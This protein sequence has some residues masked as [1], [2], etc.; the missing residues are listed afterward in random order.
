MTAGNLSLD[1]LWDR[2][3]SARQAFDSHLAI[4]ALPDEVRNLVLRGFDETSGP[5]NQNYRAPDPAVW[6]GVRV[7]SP[8]DEAHRNLQRRAASLERLSGLHTSLSADALAARAKLSADTAMQKRTLVEKLAMAERQGLVI[9]KGKNVIKRGLLARLHSEDWWHAQRRRKLARDREDA[10]RALGM[11]SSHGGLYVSDCAMEGYRLHQAR[12]LMACAQMDLLDER[13]GEVVPL[14]EIR[15]GSMANPKN[16]NTKMM[17]T[18]RGLEEYA[19]EVGHTCVMVTATCPSRFHAIHS[20]SGEPNEKFDGSTPRQGQQWLGKSWAKARSSLARRGIRIYGWRVA[21]PHHDG[22]PHWHLIIYAAV[23]D[24]PTV[25]RVLRKVWLSDCGHE[26]GALLRRIQFE[27]CDPGKSGGVGYLG[28]YLAKN[29]DG[30]LPTLFDGEEI[31]EARGQGITVATARE[32]AV[33]W[34]RVHGIRQFQGFGLPLASLWDECRRHRGRLDPHH[35]LLDMVNAAT[36][37]D[38]AKLSPLTYLKTLGGHEHWRR[39]SK[40]RMEYDAPRRRDPYFGNILRVT[41]WGELPAD[42]PVGLKCIR[43]HR[44]MHKGQAIDIPRI[45]RNRIRGDFFRLLFRASSE[46]GPV[47]L[48]VRAAINESAAAGLPKN[49]SAT[50]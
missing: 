14:S 48:T 26:P 11:V 4:E 47:A 10:M 31:D 17:V 24:M 18:A 50:P 41:R 6:E 12:M 30:A 5:A 40:C 39:E 35:P 25:R 7:K 28:K 32:R 20:D 37:T 19:A 13:T 49:G 34:S 3:T 21:E 22:T 45:E 16:R 23:S 46:L 2:R 27:E 15:A 33:C 1:L 9:P 29:M 36:G 44:V 38:T 8:W 42:R 43:L